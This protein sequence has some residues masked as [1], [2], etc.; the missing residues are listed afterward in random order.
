MKMERNNQMEII[1]KNDK[2]VAIN[3]EIRRTQMRNET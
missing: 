1:L 3:N 2:N